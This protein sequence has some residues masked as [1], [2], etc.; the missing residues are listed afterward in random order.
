MFSLESP[1]RGDSNVH[2]QCI[3]FVLKKR[4]TPNLQLWNFFL[5]TQERV[6]NSCGKQSISVRATEVLLYVFHDF[7]G[8]TV[9]LCIEIT[10]TQ[11]NTNLI[12]HRETQY[13][14]PQARKKIPVFQVTLEKRNRVGR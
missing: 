13:T 7:L 6:Q 2:T 11:G 14:I 5:G 10:L 12:L 9:E 1:H 3:I 8:R 4:I